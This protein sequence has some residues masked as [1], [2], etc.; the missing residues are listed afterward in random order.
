MTARWTKCARWRGA[1]ALCLLAAWPA[2]RADTESVDIGPGPASPW[3]DP[4]YRA[5][6]ANGVL[7]AVFQAGRLCEL[8]DRRTDRRLLSVDPADFP[9]RW[10]L[11]GDAEFSVAGCEINHRA[12]PDSVTCRYSAPNGTTWQLHRTMEPGAGDLVLRASAAT[13]QP[14]DEMRAI[15]FGCDLSEHALVTVDEVGVGRVN[16]HPW[17]GRIVQDPARGGSPSSIVPPL[18]ALFQ[19]ESR[20]WFLE[21][22]EPRIGPAL[23]MA[24]GRGDRVDLGFGRRFPR[25]T[26]T[27]PSYYIQQHTHVGAGPDGPAARETTVDAFHTAVRGRILLIG[28]FPRA[29]SIRF[30]GAYAMRNEFS[31]NWCIVR[32]LLL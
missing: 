18:V 12:G 11:F 8:R 7:E 19:G 26:R 14:V 25:T 9:Q 4:A 21:G 1:V 15:F 31:V 28:R 3:L 32:A 17:E 13:A 16:T 2:A 6:L 23:V 10:R 22:R 29:S 20:G 24:R 30:Q 27:Q 5:R